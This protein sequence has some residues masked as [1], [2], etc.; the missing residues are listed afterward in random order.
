[1]I[2][3]CWSRLFGGRLRREDDLVERSAVD[4]TRSTAAAAERSNRMRKLLYAQGRNRERLG[5]VGLL[6]SCII[7]RETLYAS[8][9]VAWGGDALDQLQAQ[10][11]RTI[12]LAQ[13]EDGAQFRAEIDNESDADA[14]L[15]TSAKLVDDP[16][17][18]QTDG[19]Q[20]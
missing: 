8:F 17:A 4:I 9:Q 20:S 16:Q 15:T 11:S 5:L 1:M 10:V 6:G 3:T 7:Q 13:T 19:G 14:L 12:G 18:S 2:T